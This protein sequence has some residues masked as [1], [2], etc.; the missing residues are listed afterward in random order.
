MLSMVRALKVLHIMQTEKSLALTGQG[1]AH[2]MEGEVR[3]P[4][5]HTH[6]TWEELPYLVILN[7]DDWN[8]VSIKLD[9]WLITR[10]FQQLSQNVL[11][12]I[13]FWCSGDLLLS[14][15]GL[16]GV[17]ANVVR[18]SEDQGKKIPLASTLLFLFQSW[19]H[20]SV[21]K[22]NL[23]SFQLFSFSYWVIISCKLV[24]P[25]VLH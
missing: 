21:S 3:A 8:L 7:N 17:A 1:D 12:C 4:G 9:W 15:L 23:F 11:L 16:W 6:R 14:S 13:C 20:D 18:R 25:N 24:S 10:E 5:A 19:K 22:V 2:G